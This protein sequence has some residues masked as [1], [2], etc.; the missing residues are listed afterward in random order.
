MAI[1]AAP[2][3]GGCAFAATPYAQFN[4]AILGGVLSS[5]PA[6]TFWNNITQL[7]GG[8]N[9]CWGSFGEDAPTGENPMFQADTY[10]TTANNV[11]T[12]PEWVSVGRTT[13]GT[14]S[15][16]PNGANF[17]LQAG[18]PAIGYGLTESYL[19][20]QSV[21]AGACYHTLETCP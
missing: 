8:N 19:P 4:A 7:Q 13:T 20:A 12:N 11:A 17:A 5:E 10:S 16:P 1:P 2:G 6:E 15:K 18:S 21:D 9:S 14:E 3:S